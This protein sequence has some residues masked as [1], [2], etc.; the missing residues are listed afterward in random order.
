[1]DQN[2]IDYLNG[3]GVSFNSYSAGNK[4]YGTDGAPNTGPVID[5]TGYM[6][7]DRKAKLRRDAMLRRMQ[8]MNKGKYMS[9][10]ALRPLPDNQGT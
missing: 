3:R 10:P 4:Q 5:K 8:M 2:F 6:E 1:M 9:S 7:R